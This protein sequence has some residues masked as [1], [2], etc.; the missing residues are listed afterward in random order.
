MKQ[1]FKKDSQELPK[2]KSRK[3]LPD[4]SSLNITEI[5]PLSKDIIKN[6]PTINIILFGE[7]Q[8]GKSK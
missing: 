4:F 5:T 1:A 2:I 7:K 3:N 6:Q 8:K